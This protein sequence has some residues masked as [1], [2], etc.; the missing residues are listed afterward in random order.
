MYMCGRGDKEHIVKDQVV[1]TGNYK[2]PSMESIMCK[3]VYFVSLFS[4]VSG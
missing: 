3:I 4:H 1:F 2:A